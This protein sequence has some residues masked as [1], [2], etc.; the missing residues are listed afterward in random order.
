ISPATPAWA[1]QML[2]WVTPWGFLYGAAANGATVRTRKIQ[3]ADYWLVTWSPTQ[4]APSGR[5]YR[6]V[7]YINPLHMVE[8][9]ETWVEHPV[10]GDMHV[11]MV[12]TDYR[13]FNGLK[14]PMRLS[15]QRVGMETFVVMPTVA[16][17]NPPDLAQLMAAPTPPVGGSASDAGAGRGAA[18]PPGPPPAP[19]VSSEKLAE[20]VYRITGGYVALAVE[21]EDYVVVLEGGQNEARG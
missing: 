18:A 6:L 20:G 12:Y 17:A 19:P 9:V 4:K 2:I 13:D 21:L 15:E 11:E 14:V 3:G 16:R 1:Q 5:A 10:L 8:R 7:G